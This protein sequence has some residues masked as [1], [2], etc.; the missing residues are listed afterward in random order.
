MSGGRRLGQRGT[1]GFPGYAIHHDVSVVLVAELERARAELERYR[2]LF[3][4]LPDAVFALD[5]EGRVTDVNTACT[6]LLG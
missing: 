3:E 4:Q 6:R 5:L 2:A 1:P